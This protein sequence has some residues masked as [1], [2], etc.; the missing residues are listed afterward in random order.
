MVFNKIKSILTKEMAE[1]RSCGRPTTFILITAIAKNNENIDSNNPQFYQKIKSQL[2]GVDQVF[3]LAPA[4]YLAILPD[5][6][7]IGGDKTAARLKKQI[8]QLLAEPNGSNFAWAAGVMSITPDFKG[9]EQDLLSELERDLLRD[10]LFDSLVEKKSAVKFSNLFQ[11]LII[12]NGWVDLQDFLSKSSCSFNSRVIQIQDAEYDFPSILAAS[13]GSS[14]VLLTPDLSEDQL[15]LIFK[16][17][18]KY[19]ELSYIPVIMLH[20]DGEVLDG[21]DP[22]L[23]PNNMPVDAV[24]KVV[25][26]LGQGLFGSR[27]GRSDAQRFS[28][29][30]SSI[31]AATH[32]LNQPLQ[33]ITGKLELALLELNEAVSDRSRAEKI[34]SL[35]EDARDQVLSAAQINSKIN[36]L[37]KI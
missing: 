13:A 8:S 25:A 32:Q 14:V 7:E 20:D 33:I 17:V 6:P 18:R 3:E 27:A 35:I 10:K 2:R 22:I 9:N 29:L 37:T 19:Q 23:L 24:A 4:K 11:C 36:R 21:P 34:A 1:I 15:H 28:D 12:D 5:T 26:G 30:L 31:S 16:I